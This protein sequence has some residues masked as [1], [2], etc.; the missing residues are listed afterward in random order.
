M[1]P[2]LRSWL[3][4]MPISDKPQATRSVSVALRTVACGLLLVAGVA[5]VGCESLQR[6]FARKPKHPA[7]APSPII[8][9]EDYT[10]AMTPEDRY[11]KHYLIF[12]YWNSELT[13]ALQHPPLNPKRYRKASADSLTELQ[14]LKTLLKDQ[15][16][17]RLAPLI[18]ERVRIVHR[19]N[20][21]LSESQAPLVL[22][23]IETQTRQL[24]RAFAPSDVRDELK[25]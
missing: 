24:H 8:Q 5:A 3:K 1:K 11:R 21:V 2:R 22:Q 13:D 4:R 16:A 15:A 17:E 20:G 23:E 7:G 14:A 19:L 18:E 10:R 9:F 12:D 6:K 25:E